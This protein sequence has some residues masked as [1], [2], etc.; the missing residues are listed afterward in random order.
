[1]LG[2]RLSNPSLQYDIEVRHIVLRRWRIHVNP[3]NTV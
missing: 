2:V 1:M 3:L